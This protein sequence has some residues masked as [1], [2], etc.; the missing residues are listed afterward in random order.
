MSEKA[1]GKYPL[2]PDELAILHKQDQAKIEEASKKLNELAQSMGYT[3]VSTFDDLG[4]TSEEIAQI[5]Y[6]SLTERRPTARYYVADRKDGG[7]AK[8][9]ALPRTD[10]CYFASFFSPSGHGTNHDFSLW[11][12]KGN[13]ENYLN[14]G[15]DGNLI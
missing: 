2:T 3:P 14:R 15:K 10:G 6:R 9:V 5:H 7:K 1:P 8:L 11:E 13:M 4:L 12:M